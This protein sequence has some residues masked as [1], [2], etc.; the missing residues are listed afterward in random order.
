MICYTFYNNDCSTESEDSSDDDIK[1]IVPKT[2]KTD[3]NVST[4][5][6]AN[7]WTFA[8]LFPSMKNS[9]GVDVHAPKKKDILLY[10]KYARMASCSFPSASNKMTT[11]AAYTKLVQQSA[12]SI[13]NTLRVTTPYVAKRSLDCYMNYTIKGKSGR[14]SPSHSDTNLY[15]RY[16]SS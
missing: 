6:A 11:A 7:P 3:K 2:D 4:T 5:S 10:K 13:D 8:H 15:R 12:F 14:L 9:Y 1:S 16:A